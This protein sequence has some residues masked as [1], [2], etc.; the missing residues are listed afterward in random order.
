MAVEV[1]IGL[2]SPWPAL[3][4]SHRHENITRPISC[5]L[6]KDIIRLAHLLHGS[7]VAAGNT[8]GCA[9][10]RYLTSSHFLPLLFYQLV[11]DFHVK[12][13]IL[14]AQ[15]TVAD[16]AEPSNSRHRFLSFEGDCFSP[17]GKPC[18]ARHRPT[19]IAV[20]ISPVADLRVMSFFFAS[21]S[22]K[23]LVRASGSGNR[24]WATTIIY[25]SQ[26]PG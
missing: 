18:C 8:P 7:A 19:A 14:S 22:I 11:A 1:S 10:H 25:L 5:K 17:A 26:P 23:P 6:R 12:G 16:C 15:L 3:A 2:S 20:M 24:G 4:S 13:H 21:A 9:L